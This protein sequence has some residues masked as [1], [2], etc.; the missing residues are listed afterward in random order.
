[1]VN[2][3]LATDAWTDQINGVVR[4]LQSTIK[5]L[6]KQGIETRVI[7]PS[8]F[9][10]FRCPF[11]PEIK[12][13]VVRN[14]EKIIELEN[15]DYVHIATEGPVGLSVRNYCVKNN[16]PFSTSYHTRFP[17]YLKK[18]CFIPENISYKFFKWFHKPAKSVLVP[19]LSMKETLDKKGFCNTVLWSR[20]VDRSEFYPMEQTVSCKIKPIFLYVGRLSKEKNIDAFLDLPFKGTYWVVGDGPD[21]ERLRKKYK[22]KATF[23]GSMK[24][25]EL[26]Q[27]YSNASVFV[28]PSKTD[29][30]GL[31]IIEALSCGLPVAAYNV[32]GPKD[33]FSNSDFVGY[34]DDSLEKAVKN[35]MSNSSKKNCCRFSEKYSWHSCTQKFIS[36]LEKVKK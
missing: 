28:F 8:L 18:I 34:L 1:M 5:E 29:T 15:Y 6:K 20:G 21:G 2:L 25:K 11:Y 24:G 7:E 14:I 17:E 32:T 36:Y 16:I 35:A 4:T 22:K 31:V 30:F 13:S 33:I 9:K 3:L 12:I 26:A 19:T 27:K 10:G 23:F